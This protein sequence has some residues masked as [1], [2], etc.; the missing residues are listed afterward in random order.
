M[1]SAL[2]PSSDIAE[3]QFPNVQSPNANTN[4][5]ISYRIKGDATT[6]LTVS[7]IAGDGTTVVKT[8][9]HNPAPPTFT[10]YDQTLTTGEADA[11]AAAGYP[12]SRLRL[13]AS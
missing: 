7:L 13:T 1:Q 2:N 11:W 3:L 8:W 5:T 10:Q 6:V 12:G 4:H 9:T